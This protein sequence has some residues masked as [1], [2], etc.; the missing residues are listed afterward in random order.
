MVSGPFPF[1]VTIKLEFRENGTQV[2]AGFQAE[3]GGFFKMAEGLVG[4]QAAKQF[5]TDLDALKL[6]ME[7]GKA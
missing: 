7:E 4:K 2:I 5:D 6:L 3:F 1:E